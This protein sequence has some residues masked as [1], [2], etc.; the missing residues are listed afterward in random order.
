MKLI[1]SGIP[2][3]DDLLGG[4]LPIDP[5]TVVSGDEDDVYPFS[6]YLLWN[7]LNA[8]NNCLYGSISRTREDV[9][10]DLD[11]SGWDVS[12]FINKGAL[13]I[14]DALSL[15]GN[16]IQSTDE[17]LKILLSIKEDELIPE[18]CYLALLEGFVKLG[19]K[20]GRFIAILDSIDKLIALMGLDNTLRF[21][22]LMT[23]LLK[24]T[25][26]VGIGLLY[27]NYIS[28]ETLETI[29]DAAGT[30]IELG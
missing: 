10:A 13:R 17:R 27:S 3:L 19:W 12:R 22:D 23:N 21:K 9:K 8:G 29:R 7:Q 6:Q 25:S 4:G 2:N 11:A 14:V 1:T 16:D 26:G 24:D 18:R 15:V 20:S 28:N 30:F 5:D